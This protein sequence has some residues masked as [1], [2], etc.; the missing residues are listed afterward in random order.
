MPSWHPLLVDNSRYV[1]GPNLTTV[2]S[3]S[4]GAMQLAAVLV[5][6]TET[7]VPGVQM[8]SQPGRHR[9]TADKPI[10]VIMQTLNRTPI[11][12]ISQFRGMCCHPVVPTHVLS[13]SDPQFI[14]PASFL[15][16][17]QGPCVVFAI[18]YPLSAPAAFFSAFDGTRRLGSLFFD[19]SAR[20]RTQSAR[21]WVTFPD[22]RPVWD[23]R[24]VPEEG[25]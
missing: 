22:L 23:R 6:D 17:P 25:S 2:H 14:C 10:P 8:A 7:S 13:C 9:C 4:W 1:P 16:G 21:R 15:G 5:R 18:V 19:I 12:P 11:V 20:L 3:S 24:D